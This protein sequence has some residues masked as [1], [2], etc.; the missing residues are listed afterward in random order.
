MTDAS[1]LR[2][3]YLA[4]NPIAVAA[5]A[6][7][8]E[9][10]R[11]L[12]RVA[13]LLPHREPLRVLDIGCGTGRVSIRWCESGARVTGVDM[14]PDF[15]ARARE[16]LREHAARF[17]VV[18]GD[19]TRLPLAPGGFDVVTLLAL[20]EHVPD[21]RRA[22]TEAARMVAPGG[23]FMLT[24]TNRRHPFQGEVRGFPF[25]PWLPSRLRDRVLSW[26]MEHRRDLVNYTDWPAV[27]WFDGGE[28]RDLLVSLGLEPHS[29]FDL[30]RPESLTGAR[31]LGRWLLPSGP[32]SGLGRFA[33]SFLSRGV[34][35]YARRP[36]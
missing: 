21:W 11:E 9:F 34:V 19:A 27:H 31:A 20:L 33:H 7:Q 23:V 3:K 15:A 4:N 35:F 29:R 36:A 10:R 16:R 12:E 24:T 14:D 5:P 6:D 2:E 13:P 8:A 32:V 1:G 26:I 17:R 30:L 25:Y 22:V 28:I 18:V